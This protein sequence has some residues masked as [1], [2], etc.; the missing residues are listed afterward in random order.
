MFS[1]TSQTYQHWSLPLSSRFLKFKR[2]GFFKVN[3]DAAPCEWSHPLGCCS[4]QM[5]GHFPRV[6]LRKLLFAGQREFHQALTWPFQSC[7]WKFDAPSRNQS[8]CLLAQVKYSTIRHQY[9]SYKNNYCNFQKNSSSLT[10]CLVWF[11]TF[12][13]YQNHV[14]QANT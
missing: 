5:Y 6:S 10:V 8:M 7:P 4:P 14:S 12:M 9:S 3:S 13:S 11:I 2:K 1:K